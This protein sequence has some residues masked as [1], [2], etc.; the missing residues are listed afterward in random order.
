M[1]FIKEYKQNK[2]DAIVL[3]W[4]SIAITLLIAGLIILQVLAGNL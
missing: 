1:T 3:R 2:Q 4:L